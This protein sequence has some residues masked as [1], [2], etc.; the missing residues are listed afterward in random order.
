V[1]SVS[2]PFVL[3]LVNLSDSSYNVGM[4]LVKALDDFLTELEV[5]EQKSPLTLRNYQHYLERFIGFAKEQGVTEAEA[6][7]DELVT[8][9]RVYLNRL[10][11]EKGETL[12]KSTQN[13]HVI[14]LRSFLKF[15]AKRDIKTLL[16]EKI[17]LMRTGERTVDF[18]EGTDLER[19]LNAPLKARSPEIIKLRDKAILEMLFS[20]G[21]RVSE[22]ANLKINSLNLKKD[23]FTVRGKGDKPRVVFISN[24]AKYHLKNYLAARHDME[25]WLFVSHDR[26]ENK[27]ARKQESK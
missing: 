27:K 25:P 2:Y 13:Y 17:E 26:A 22:L 9:Y 23:E 3:G 20:T 11:D 4:T 18:L 10:A 15:L 12:K 21:L 19:F 7:T 24:Q 16:P 1:T 14:A 8:K 6:V 5:A